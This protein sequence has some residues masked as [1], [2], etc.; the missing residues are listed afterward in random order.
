MKCNFF[1]AGS[2]WGKNNDQTERFTKDSI[3]EK[4]FEDDSYS[5]TINKIKEGDILIIKSTYAQNGVSYL[6]VKALG[7]VTHNPQDGTLLNVD[8]RITGLWIDVEDLGFY[9]NTISMATVADVV[10]IFTNIQK[11]LWQR[12]LPAGITSTTSSTATATSNKIPVLISD[13]DKGLDY[14]DI[15]KDVKAFAR[16]VAAKSF[17]PPIAI[18]LFGK[19]GSGKS[20]FMR[21]LREQ[22]DKLSERSKDEFYCK[23]VVHIHFNA[24]SYVDAN[25]WASIVSKIFEGLKDYI[26]INGKETEK[27]EIEKQLAGKLVI[28]Q[29]SIGILESQKETLTQQIS[30]LEKKKEKA[31]QDLKEALL[32]I[33][34]KT[35]SSLI[36]NA[37]TQFDVKNRIKKAS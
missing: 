29:E 25:L 15:S 14:L 8:W 24:W 9:R 18:A 32:K 20:F 36:E 26:S 28:A 33:E 21:K 22:V 11:G 30:S 17:E 5:D 4:G 2:S 6:K 23:G 34:N 1:L 35:L 27:A 7:I 16:V 13:S 3:W 31:N 10:T 12:M 19:W 37:G